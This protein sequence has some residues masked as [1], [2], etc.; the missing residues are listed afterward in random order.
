MFKYLN[1]GWLYEYLIL[2]FWKHYLNVTCDFWNKLTFNK[3]LDERPTKT[4]QK[5]NKKEYWTVNK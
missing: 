5:Q 4:F 3:T 1:N 2:S